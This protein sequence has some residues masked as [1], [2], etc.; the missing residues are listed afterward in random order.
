MREVANTSYDCFVFIHCQ[1]VPRLIVGRLN[2]PVVG[3]EVVGL[4]GSVL[5]IDSTSEPL[6]FRQK[7]LVPRR[8][9]ECLIELRCRTV[10]RSKQ[11]TLSARL[12]RLTS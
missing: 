10:T 4:K 6:R 3:R 7:P 8:I 12:A 1:K 2:V 5:Y 9:D 11:D